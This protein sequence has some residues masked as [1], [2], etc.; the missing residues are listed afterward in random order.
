MV[1][2]YGVRAY[3]HV[4]YAHQVHHVIV[5][6]KHHVDVLFRIVAQGVGHRRDADHTPIPGAG[7]ERIVLYGTLGLS[8]CVSGVVAEDGRR[9]RVLDGL[10]SR[11]MAGVGQVY[12]HAQLVHTLH[13]RYSEIAE[14]GVGAF[15]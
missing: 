3:P 5:V 9:F 11:L 1:A 7:Q 14:A 4:V 8:Q 2:H 12:R 6:V 15:V 10:Q 13:D